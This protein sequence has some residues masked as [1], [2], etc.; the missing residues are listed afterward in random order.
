MPVYLKDPARA[1]TYEVCGGILDHPDPEVTLRHEAQDELGLTLGSVEPVFAAFSSP[2]SLTEKVHYF[3]APYHA[4][5]RTSP[6]GGLLDEGEHI[7]VVELPFP[8]ALE[9]IRT[10]RIEDARTIA[11]LYFLAA[12]GRLTP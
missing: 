12:T 6:G 4:A 7:Q 8:Q 11:L 3:L 1:I 9:H 5:Q 10:G 2:G